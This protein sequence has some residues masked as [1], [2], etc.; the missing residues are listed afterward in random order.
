MSMH[1][2]FAYGVEMTLLNSSLTM[3]RSAVGVLQL[4]G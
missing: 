2:N 4:S 1:M 3:S